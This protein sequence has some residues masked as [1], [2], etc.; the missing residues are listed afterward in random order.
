MMLPRASWLLTFAI[1]TLVHGLRYDPVLDAWNLN[2]AQDATDPVDYWG[3]RNVTGTGFQYTKSP[4]NWR[5][6]VYTLFLDRWVNGDPTN[7]NANNT[8]YEQDSHSNQ[9]RL[10][11]DLQGLVDSLDYIAGMGV[12]AIYIAGSIFINQP[13]G[14]DSYSVGLGRPSLPAVQ[15]PAL[16]WTH[17]PRWR[18]GRQPSPPV[19]T[20]RSRST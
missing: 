20:I 1:F 10:G 14:S 8:I 9:M 19:L 11:G 6:P 13:W 2:K 7:D 18:A 4:D 17:T 3:Q 15:T 12:K 16:R 5:F